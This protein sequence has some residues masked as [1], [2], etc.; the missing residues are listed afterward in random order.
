MKRILALLII[1]QALKFTAVC[2]PAF[3]NKVKISI[4]NGDTV[5]IFLK[6]DEFNKFAVSM[7][8][9]VLVPRNDT[10]YYLR[11]YSHSGIAISDISIKDSPQQIQKVKFLRADSM[12]LPVD[13]KPQVSRSRRQVM[14]GGVSNALIILIE[15]PDKRFA[16]TKQEITA[17][18][19]EIGYDQ[20]GAQ[21]SV[22]DF[23][24][25]ASYGNFDLVSDVYGPYSANY[26]MN[27][28]GGNNAFGNDNNALALAEEAIQNL[29]DDIDLSVYDNDGNGIV[30][31]VHIIFAGYGEEAGGPSSAIWS[32]EYPYPLSVTKNGYKFAGYSCTPE[33]R[34]NMGN[35][36]SRIGV[37]CHE[38]GHA[39]GA[40]DFYDVDYSSNGS[41]EG[42]GV[43]DIMA[44]GSWNNSG[45]TP[46]NFNP[47]VKI[48]DFGWVTPIN[49]EGNNTFALPSYNFFPSVLRLP[50]GNP[51]DY[52]LLEYRTRQSFDEALPGEGVLIYHVHP[53][54]ESRRASNM[55]NNRHPQCLYPVC[56]SS[57]VSPQVTSDYGN[58][59]SSGCPFPGSTSNHQFSKFTVP[60]AFQW[61]GNSPEFSISNIHLSDDKAFLDVS[62]NESNPIVPPIESM[63]YIEDFENG[64]NHLY[65]EAIEG[66]A[67]W[68]IYP[69][70]NLST[71]NDMPTPYGEKH[72]LMLYSGKKTGIFSKSTIT[73]ERIKLNTDST[74]TLSFWI[75]T[76]ENPSSRQPKLKFLIQD[77]DTYQWTKIFE[78]TEKFDEWCEID[79]PLPKSLTSISYRL[80]GEIL[81]NGIFIDDIKIQGSAP[82]KIV[83][84]ASINGRI[85]LRN[86]PFSI[87]SHD[88]V[89]VEI[90]NITGK[91]IQKYN[92]S[93]NE[94]ATPLL[95]SGIYIIATDKGERY[96]V[97]I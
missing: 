97:V 85:S 43:W 26:S 82:S 2:V 30:D 81:D 31:N 76:M 58:I 46:A 32:H 48:V 66:K 56:A 29:P 79:L 95:V 51:G 90:Y 77:P 27:F 60:D 15:Y 14:S 11:K 96:K 40:N 69:S 42:T 88:Y 18:L 33:L 52:Y 13:Q 4:E 24:R 86:K 19:N 53:Q 91:L 39:F 28:Y 57:N 63:T 80:S 59:N 6:G 41:Y 62:I 71:V 5:E 16:K 72:A 12:I 9:Y 47:Y 49:I 8:G 23:Y 93:P 10:W 70:K 35:G 55:I 44:S 94:S 20:D 75:R 64:I 25:Y 74:Y 89:N 34:S 17:L 1:L 3:P 78:N 22:R 50:T 36:I 87:L 37:I 73:S 45:V 7:D 83:D 65:S 84:I 61:D 21:G 92:M 54:I 67:K 38:L 68:E